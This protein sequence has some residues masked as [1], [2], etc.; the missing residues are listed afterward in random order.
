MKYPTERDVRN[1]VE[2]QLLALKAGTIGGK[3][4]AK[5]GTMI[6]RY[7]AEDFFTLRRFTQTTS[8]SLIDLHI[9]PRWE[10]VRLADVTPIAARV[11]RGLVC[12]ENSCTVYVERSN[13][14][15]GV[16][17]SD[18]GEPCIFAFGNH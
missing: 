17:L 9:R 15:V 7:M 8:K 5:L 4:A 12:G 1:A 18:I 2:G 16:T 3:L 14:L 10:G 13:Q 6:D 11:L